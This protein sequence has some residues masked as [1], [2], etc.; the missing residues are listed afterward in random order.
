MA[1]SGLALCLHPFHTSSFETPA[2]STGP[3]SPNHTPATTVVFSSTPVG[4]AALRGAD[5]RAPLNSSAHLQTPT[6]AVSTGAN[7]VDHLLP[8]LH[9]LRFRHALVRP[10]PLHFLPRHHLRHH[11]LPRR[12]LRHHF[13][14]HRRGP[15]LHHGAKMSTQR[16]NARARQ[17]AENA[18]RHG[19]GENAHRR[20][21]F[22]EASRTS[23]HCEHDQEEVV[24]ERRWGA[25]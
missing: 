6:A 18:P 14:L 19:C 25:H 7:L 3:S 5:P 23:D 12:H 15:R 13:H 21:G 17:A 8:R 9:P 20:A 24:R 16:Q 1:G 2:S 4:T 22:A 10:H 11:F